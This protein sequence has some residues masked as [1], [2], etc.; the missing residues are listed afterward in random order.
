MMPAAPTH[1]VVRLAALDLRPEPDHRAELGSQLW[2]GET[3]RLLTRTP[4]RG[5]WKVCSRSDGYEGWVRDWG[6]VTV[7]AARAARWRRRARAEVARLFVELRARPGAG[8]SVGPLFLGARVIPG[9]RSGAYR[10]VELPDA[11]RGWLAPR[12]L[13]AAGEASADILGRVSSLLG[14]PYLWGGRTPA[15]LDCSAFTQIVLAEQGVRL[16][17]DARQQFGACRPLAAGSGPRLGDLAFFAR[18]GEPPSHVGI[19][20]GDGGFAHARGVVCL[21]SLD[22]HNPLYDKELSGQFVGWF[23]PRPGGS[24]R[25][26]GRH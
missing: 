4:R 2:L 24:R 10:A 5:W 26:A 15:G 22:P 23:R 18:P 20:L 8:M 11:R 19:A 12:D 16:P 1:G 3:V 17:R 13:R 21:A 25:A 7:S 6:L 9:R 14:T